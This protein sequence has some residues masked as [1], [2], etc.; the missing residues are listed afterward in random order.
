MTTSPIRRV[1]EVLEAVANVRGD[2]AKRLMLHTWAEVFH[3]E[4][5]GQYGN[6]PPA[7]VE[8]AVWRCL[9]DLR[10]QLAAVEELVDGTDDESDMATV[11]K[12]ARVLTSMPNLQTACETAISNHLRP[13][14]LTAWRFAARHY[15]GTEEAI[16]GEL[17]GELQ[18]QLADLEQSLNDDAVPLS[19]RDFVRRQ[20]ARIREALL[21]YPVC[22]AAPLVEALHASFGDVAINGPAISDVAKA[23]EPGRSIIAKFKKVLDGVVA[24]CA[25]AD[26][27]NKGYLLAAGAIAKALPLIK[28]AVEKVMN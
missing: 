5:E 7:H 9:M 19:L 1:C 17:L 23:S 27:L 16:S 14:V 13:E 2:A 4:Y 12:H 18:R 11:I 20:I 26:K 6:T 22:G 24:V 3:L 21:R 10:A 8:E 15:A 25:K 28:E